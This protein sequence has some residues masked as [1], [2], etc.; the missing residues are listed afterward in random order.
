MVIG[1]LGAVT[2]KHEE[3]LQR[4]PGTTSEISVQESAAIWRK[5]SEVTF[6]SS[7]ARYRRQQNKGTSGAGLKRNVGVHREP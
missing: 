2:P 3:Q 4:V 6:E 1:T 7:P 5:A